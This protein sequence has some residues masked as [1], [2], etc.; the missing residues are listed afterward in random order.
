MTAGTL[1]ISDV[2]GTLLR[3]DKTLS[4]RNQ[5]AVR[6]LAAEGIH[7]TVSSSRPPFGLRA[8]SAQLGLRVPFGA[9]TMYGQPMQ[10]VRCNQCY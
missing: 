10:G 1:V 3:S 2:D 9:C 5:M 6:Q 8:L 4:P 7:F